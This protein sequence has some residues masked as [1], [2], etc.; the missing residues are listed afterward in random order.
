MTV[1]TDELLD[2]LDDLAGDVDRAEAKVIRAAEATWSARE[3]LSGC[4]AGAELD[5]R[6]KALAT[7][8]QAEHLAVGEL[9]AARTVLAAAQQQ[10]D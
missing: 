8:A 2:R 9:K 4:I 6:I 1:T 5:A 7:C 3:A 10:E